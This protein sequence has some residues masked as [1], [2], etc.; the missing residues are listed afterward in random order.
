[1]ESGSHSKRHGTALNQNEAFHHKT[2]RATHAVNCGPLWQPL[3]FFGTAQAGAGFASI[4]FFQAIAIAVY[5]LWMLVL[6]S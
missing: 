6:R 2:R 1:M 4:T 5:S 3:P